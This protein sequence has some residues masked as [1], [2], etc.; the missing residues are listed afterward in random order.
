MSDWRDWKDRSQWKQLFKADFIETIQIIPDYLRHPRQIVVNH[1]QW[2]W[3]QIFIFQVIISMACG[4]LSNLL[5]S[6]FL[7]LFFAVV[8]APIA[9][10][11][12]VMIITG[13]FFYTA[14]L[15]WE[16]ELDFRK[17]YQSVLLCALPMIFVQI[18]SG[19]FPPVN[20]LGLL[21]SGYLL[22]CA[23]TDQFRMP[24]T[25]VRNVLAFM[26]AACIL[27]WAMQ[28]VEFHNNMMNMRHKATPKSLDLLE[29]ELNQ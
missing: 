16:K 28:W 3:P 25:S 20:L 7:A 13:F 18:V 10:I 12:T 8:I 9:S 22:Y 21:A 29:E 24:R 11:F 15:I 1:P 27:F 17:L 2:D 5:A 4:V 14:L 6:R 23:L 19:L 26:A